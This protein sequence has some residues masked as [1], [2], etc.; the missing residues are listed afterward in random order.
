[1]GLIDR[2]KILQQACTDR[3]GALGV[4]LRAVEISPLHTGAEGRAVV[5]ARD[6]GLA[7]FESIAMDE[8]GMGAVGETRRPHRIWRTVLEGET[9]G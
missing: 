2:Q 7:E 1:M 8:V 6:R 9:R 3:G 5:S 4:K